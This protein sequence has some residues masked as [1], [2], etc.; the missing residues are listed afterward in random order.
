MFPLI[1]CGQGR[2]REVS[3]EEL[4]MIFF[5]HCCPLASRREQRQSFLLPS[6]FGFFLEGGRG[7]YFGVY[8]HV[9]RRS[10]CQTFCGMVLRWEDLEREN[11]GGEK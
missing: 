7:L 11:R 4:N 5:R 6:N 3:E 2:E 8:D 1:F 10:N 9:S